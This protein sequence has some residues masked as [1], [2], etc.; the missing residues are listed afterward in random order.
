MILK[1]KYNKNRVSQPTNSFLTRFSFMIVTRCDNIMLQKNR[2]WQNFVHLHKKIYRNYYGI[3]VWIFDSVCD[4][5]NMISI[6]QK[7]GWSDR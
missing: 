7:K 3:P 2:K 6:I 5:M 1:K 4:I